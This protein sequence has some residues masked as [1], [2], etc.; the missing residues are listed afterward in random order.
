M[1]T[2]SQQELEFYSDSHFEPNEARI[3]SGKGIILFTS[4]DPYY[5]DQAG[6]NNDECEY[7]GNG[8]IYDEKIFIQNYVFDFSFEI[9]YHFGKDSLAMLLLTLAGQGTPISEQVFFIFQV[10]PIFKII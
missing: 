9:K 3:A 5:T 10:P 1:T 8:I 7:F 6:T 4:N 2:S